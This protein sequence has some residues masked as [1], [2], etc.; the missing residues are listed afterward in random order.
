MVLPLIAAWAGIFFLMT[1]SNLFNSSTL[2]MLETKAHA[3][4]TKDQLHRVAS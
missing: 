1:L 3:V 4:V 2:S